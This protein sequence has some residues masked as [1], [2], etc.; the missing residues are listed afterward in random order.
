MRVRLTTLAENTPASPALLAELGLS[1]LIEAG[2]SCLLLDAGQTVSAT[3]NAGIV[4]ADLARVDKIVLSHGHFDHTG[5]LRDLLPKIGKGVEVVCHPDV[6]PAKY[7]IRAGH[8][9]RFVGIPYTQ[10]ALESLD[11]RFTMS[12]EPVVLADHIMTTGEVPMVTDF[13]T[14]DP[15][16]FVKDG[17]GFVPDPLLDDLAI[18]IDSR[19]GLTVVLGCAHRGIINTLYH[20][21][22]LTGRSKI[23]LVVGGSHL[24]G[25]SEERISKTIAA[26][27][28]LGVGR[29][30]LCHCTSLP[31]AAE[32]AHAFG[33]AFFFNVA[34][35]RTEI[36]V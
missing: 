30:G 14:I 11:A 25:A 2:P 24:V 36:E 32:I 27:K 13:E 20:A 16:L 17:T 3:H 5:G 31:A 26:L 6:W 10:A 7:D 4:G 9:A 34:G 12:R 29:L 1:I 22:R 18:I 28:A 35:N 23:S 33:D 15:H 19:D 21:R 8:P